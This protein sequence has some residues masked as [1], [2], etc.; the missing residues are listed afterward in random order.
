MTQQ[1]CGHRPRLQLLRPAFETLRNHLDLI[2]GTG[3]VAITVRA[4]VTASDDVESFLVGAREGEAGGSA[5]RRDVPE[6]VAF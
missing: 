2:N 5:R 6:I 1:P 3:L 4:G